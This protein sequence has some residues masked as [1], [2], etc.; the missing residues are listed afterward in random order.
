MSCRHSTQLLSESRDREL[1]SAERE[2]LARHLDI[3]P[4]CRRCE[5]QFEL[6]RL[7]LQALVAD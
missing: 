7:A 3:C 2:T 5:R 1:S 6:L 4:A